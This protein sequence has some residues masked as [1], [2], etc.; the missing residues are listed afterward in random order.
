[1]NAERCTVDTNILFYALDHTDAAKQIQAERILD[2]VL[3]SGGPLL[4]QTLG[5][6]CHAT[7]RKRPKLLP[8]A[9]RFAL[10]ATKVFPIASAS[11][12]DFRSAV[13]ANEEHGLPFWDAMLWAT[14]RRSACSVLLTEDLQ[15]NRTLGGTRFLNPFQMTKETIDAMFG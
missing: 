13:S 5:E 1:M 10:R 6:L 4:L 3:M 9:R 7:A 11:P 15:S 2:L 8:E 14:A 12:E